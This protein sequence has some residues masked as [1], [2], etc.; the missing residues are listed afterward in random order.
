MGANMSIAIRK[1]PNGQ[2]VP[3]SES[4]TAPPTWR[5]VMKSNIALWGCIALVV[6][7]VYLIA[8]AFPETYASVVNAWKIPWFVLAIPGLIVWLV[9]IWKVIK[10]GIFA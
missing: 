5:F 1:T 8:A 6:T 3:G 9:L 2:A 10:E 4:G 7:V